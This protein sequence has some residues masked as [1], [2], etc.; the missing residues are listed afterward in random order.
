MKVDAS[1]KLVDDQR[2]EAVLV[3]QVVEGAAAAVHLERS[4]T[5]RGEWSKT[6]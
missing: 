5:P 1:S 3:G 6:G 2:G 4:L